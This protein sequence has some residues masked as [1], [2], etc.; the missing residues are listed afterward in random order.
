VHDFSGQADEELDVHAGEQV[1]PGRS[2]LLGVVRDS[3]AQLTLSGKG[4]SYGAGWVEVRTSD[5][6]TGV[7]P[8]W[9]VT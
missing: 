8:E 4:R 6:R 3:A 5:G 2:C 7:V 9:S 1:R